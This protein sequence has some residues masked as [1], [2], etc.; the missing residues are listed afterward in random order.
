LTYNSRVNYTRV[1]DMGVSAKLLLAD[2]Q[3]DISRVTE[4][5]EIIVIENLVTEE[6][7]KYIDRVRIMQYDAIKKCILLENML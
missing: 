7:R 2:I 1:I 4:M 5:L 6:E 3:F